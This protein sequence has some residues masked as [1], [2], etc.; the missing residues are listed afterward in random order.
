MVHAAPKRL[1]VLHKSHLFMVGTLVL[2]EG[3]LKAALSPCPGYPEGSG[4]AMQLQ[5][6]LKSVSNNLKIIFKSFKISFKSP[7]NMLQINFI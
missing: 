4:V 7:S 2:S 3:V 5:I 1:S 6:N